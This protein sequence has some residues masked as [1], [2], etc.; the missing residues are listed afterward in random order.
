[1][2]YSDDCYLSCSAS[3]SLYQHGDDCDGDKHGKMQEL[4]RICEY[5]HVRK[6]WGL[7]GKAFLSCKR[8]F[9]RDVTQLPI[10]E[11]PLSHYVHIYGLTGCFAICLQSTNGTGYHDCV[12]E[13]FL[14]LWNTISTDPRTFLESLLATVNKHLRGFKISPGEGL[15]LGE[16]LSVAVAN[17]FSSINDEPDSFD[18]SSVEN[19]VVQ[20]ELNV[21]QNMY[22][23]SLERISRAETLEKEYRTTETSLSREALVKHFGKKLDD[24]ADILGASRSTMKHACRVHGI[25]K[26]PFPKKKK[27]KPPPSSLKHVNGFVQGGD[28]RVPKFGNSENSCSDPPLMHAMSVAAHTISNITP[29]QDVDGV[30]VK[31]TYGVEMIRFRLSF[32]SRKAD[33]V[34]KMTQRFPLNDGT[35]NIKYEDDDGDWILIVCDE[36]PEECIAISKSKGIIKMLVQPVASQ[37]P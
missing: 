30:T 6:G 24:A 7:V 25:K 13:F 37:A 35:F 36:D 19:V 32:S 1:M 3:S 22:V 8:C 10:A 18:D 28:E 12:L 26:W 17:N 9:C 20:N 29:K 2:A 4:S 34:E 23:T 16:E 33:L 15:G 5:H 21:M 11:H 27:F 31:A 14:H